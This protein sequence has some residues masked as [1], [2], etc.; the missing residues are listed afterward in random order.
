[1]DEARLCGSS[2]PTGP[3]ALPA[4]GRSRPGPKN[5]T[6][7][8]RDSN[9]RP[10]DPQSDAL[11]TA[12]R[13]P[14]KRSTLI[15]TTAHVQV[16]MKRS[17]WSKQHQQYVTGCRHGHQ[18]HLTITGVGIAQWLERRT[19]DRKVPGSSPGISGGNTFFSGVNLLCWL[20]FRYPFYPRVNAVAR[21]QP[22]SF[23]QKCR[24]QA[25]AKT[26]MHPTNM[27]LN[28]VTL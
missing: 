1:M 3:I 12:L 7:L 26:H 23:C 6:W 8:W 27:A 11:T 4:L 14:V 17:A 21:K 18:L 9:P 15:K 10:S 16:W 5:P 20:V 25:T 22:Q 19:R 2:L 24:W 13:G 28:K